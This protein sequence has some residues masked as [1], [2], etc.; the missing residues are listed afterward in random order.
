MF[1]KPSL[2]TRIAV[3]KILGFLIG[4][5]GFILLP[6]VTPDTAPML[7]WGVLCWYTTFGAIIG[8]FGVLNWH[9]VLKLPMPWWFR[10]PLI[11]AWM[12]FV[13]TLIAYNQLQ[14]VVIALFGEDSLFNSPF[15]FV[16]EGAL[17]GLVIGYFA[18]RFGGEGK[19]TISNI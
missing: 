13:L 4:L 5:C 19:A 8:V 16:L 9:P 1:E 7:R 18:K 6:V 10:D 15:W 11:G 17:V 12:N 14:G 2:F 3:G